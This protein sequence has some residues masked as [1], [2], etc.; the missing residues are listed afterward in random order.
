[1]KQIKL[2]TIKKEPPITY[3]MLARIARQRLCL[4]AKGETLRLHNV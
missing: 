2:A 4:H 1:M 3:G